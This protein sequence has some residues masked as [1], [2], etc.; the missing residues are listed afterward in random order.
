M[1]FY[2]FCKANSQDLMYWASLFS[3]SSYL[4]QKSLEPIYFYM[5][6]S[7]S[8]SSENQPVNKYPKSQGQKRNCET[9][10]ATVENVIEVQIIIR[11]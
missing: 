2:V 6:C 8:A 4:S 10:D 1:P 9:A 11:F 5:P 3:L 7:S